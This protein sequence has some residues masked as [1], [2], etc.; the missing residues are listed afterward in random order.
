[1]PLPYCVDCERSYTNLS[2]HFESRRHQQRACTEPVECTIC[3]E[4]QS[5]EVFVKC[6]QCVHFWCRVCDTAMRECPFCRYVS[7]LQLYTQRRQE[8]ALRQ[9]F[10]KLRRFQDRY[11]HCLEGQGVQT[12]LVRMTWAEIRILARLTQHSA[13]Q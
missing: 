13:V 5:R 1:M 9:V 7:P 6:A 4:E 2:A 11:Q 3:K 12:I 10:A 8:R